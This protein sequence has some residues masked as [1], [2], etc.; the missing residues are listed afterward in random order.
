MKP[1]CYCAELAESAVLDM[2]SSLYAA[3]GE[4]S[5]AAL[6]TLDVTKERGEPRWWLSARRCRECNQDWLVA[7][8]ER[9]NDV[10]CLRR[11]T[12]VEA[13]AI[14]AADRWPPD[15]DSYESLLEMG[16]RAGRSVRWVD[17]MDSSLEASIEELVRSR[18][19]I[20]IPEIARLLDL[21][22]MLARTLTTR[23]ARENGLSIELGD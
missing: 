6:E 5:D 7:Q 3:E 22:E 2:G 10:Y 19:S 18:P 23:V 20:R 1:G 11:L 17:P 4:L 16:A 8:E 14:V 15:F 12:S 21:D 9:Q 13:N